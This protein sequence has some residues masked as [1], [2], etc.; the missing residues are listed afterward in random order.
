MYVRC[1]V[2]CPTLWDL[3]T[4]ARQASPSMGFSRQGYW[5]GLPFP[6]PGDL[7]HQ[8]IESGSPTLQVDFSR[9]EPPGKPGSLHLALQVVSLLLSHWGS[10]IYSVSSKW[11]WLIFPQD[12]LIHTTIGL[13]F[14]HPSLPQL[15][16]RLWRGLGS[17]QSSG[18][19]PWEACGVESKL[20][21]SLNQGKERASRY[22]EEE[23]GISG[24]THNL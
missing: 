24:L 3:W 4:V 15:P 10:L 8:G 9:F 5:S 2:V 20:L 22:Q 17:G 14:T 18:R 19:W 23:T 13:T 16:I 1:L 6:S 21:S 7:P 12:L 11:A